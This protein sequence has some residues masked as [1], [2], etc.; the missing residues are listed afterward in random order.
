[1]SA[2]LFTSGPSHATA[3]TGS[4]PYATGAIPDAAERVDE[5]GIYVFLL[6]KVNGN[7]QPELV[8]LEQRGRKL[9]MLPQTARKLGF[10][11]DYLERISPD[12][13]LSDYPSI[14]AVYDESRQTLD[15]TAPLELLDIETTILGAESRTWTQ[16]SVSPGLLFNYDLYS[17]FDSG[18]ARALNLF[19][20]LRAFNRWGTASTTYLSKL[21]QPG[22][23]SAL[24]RSTV[25]LDSRLE[26]SWQDA[27][28]TLRLGDTLTSGLPWTRQTLIGGVR[29]AR[30][31]S[32][33][34]Y[35]VTAPLPAYFGAVTQ[36]SSVQLYVD[37]I[38]Q[39][40][41]QIPA[42]PFQLNFQP[43]VNGAGRAQVVMT[44][45]LGRSTSV[46][47]PF[48]GT[49]RLLRAGLADWS[50]EAGY[51]RKSY[52]FRSFDYGHALVASGTVRR[53]V[54]DRTTVSGHAEFGDRISMGGLG[55]DLLVGNWGTVSASMAGSRGDGSSGSQHSLG[56]Q[57]QRGVYS[58][59]WNS[60]RANARFRDVASRYGS[61]PTLR[62]DSAYAGVSFASIGNF[63]VNY[64]RFETTDRSRARYAGFSWSRSLFR[65]A[66]LSLAA[67][68]NLD[69]R[70]DRT[71]TFSL[72]ANF[73][74][75][76]SGYA[77]ATRTHD[78]SS[79]TLSASGGGIGPEAWNWN[80]RAQRSERH[81]AGAGAYKSA[82]AE[83]S[84]QL[85]YADIDAGI[86]QSGNTRSVHAQAA[87]S[88]VA[89]G[90]EIFAARRI[91]DGFAVVSTDS[92]PDIP[93]FVENRPV[94]RTDANG[95][96]LVPSLHAYEN[97]RISIDPIQLP[98]DMHIDQ[99]RMNAVPRRNSGVQ[100][101]FGMQRVRA[102][103]LIVHL[104]DGV[105][106]P[107]GTAAYLNDSTEPD[108]WVGYD[109]R[110]YLEGLQNSNRVRL[111]GKQLDC[112][113]AFTL[114]DVADV[115]P[116]I[117]PFSC[118]H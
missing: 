73:G 79:R 8:R 87:G 54:T 24:D 62:S 108:G 1:M 116:E 59:G 51:V 38:R 48:Y 14:Q 4:A 18:N 29:I 77:A 65:G 45:A 96:L 98:P 100:V 81:G 88:I 35:Q 19:S 15:I 17:S 118:R 50:F 32:L 84:R 22:D 70:R 21:F 42:G 83:V 30:D 10:R 66:T 86:Y 63:G 52:G 95:L 27:R 12:T 53:G 64:A 113:I 111:Q 61:G 99:V 46:Q 36:P 31:F 112:T 109:G 58:L 2:A 72:I 91:Y 75:G 28:V 16:A 115:V 23:G 78:G 40:S 90:G 55:I 107:L 49:S 3:S 44:D 82:S 20:E 13:P 25:R 114:D 94:G 74:S 80:L 105:P 102:A 117:G 7:P 5:R 67:T 69:D 92:V 103:S 68:Q 101:A 26:V 43:S 71:I 57:L 89:M 37:G 47:F 34:P 41:G 6:T 85:Q 76:V 9:Y 33:Q 39:Y 11:T 93:V 97:N 60:Q 106:V 104:P 110:L 56:Y